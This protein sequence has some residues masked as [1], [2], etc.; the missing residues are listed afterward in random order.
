MLRNLKI[1]NLPEIEEKVLNFWERNKIFEK[2][3]ALRKAKG[4]PF[5]FF[6]GPPTANGLPHVGHAL[7]RAFKD[8]VLRY[9]TM[10]GRYVSRRAGWDTHG[11]P[12]EIAVE[13]ELG[14]KHKSE[15]EKLGIAEFN[16]MAKLSVWRYKGEWERFTKRIGFWLDFSNPYITYENSYMETLWWIFGEIEKRGLLKKLHK[17]IPWCTRCQTPL[18]NNE[19]AQPSAYQKVKD[20][21]VYFKLPLDRKSRGKAGREYLLVWTTT[22]WTIPANVAVA[23]NPN[24]TY[25]KFKVSDGFVWSHLP[26]PEHPGVEAVAVEKMAGAKFVGKSYEPAYPARSLSSL[27]RKRIYRVLPADFVSTN[28]G[29][30]FVHISPAFGEDDFKLIQGENFG[31][32]PQE[33]IP[34]FITLDERG[35]MKKGFPGAGKFMKDADHDVI[36]DL[37]R[38]GFLYERGVVEHNYPFCWRCETPL[39]YLAR[40]T[41]FIEMSKITSDLLA[42]NAGVNWIPSHIREGRFG[43]WIREGKD[44]SISRERYWGTPLPIWEGERCSHRLVV[45]SFE[46]L[47]KFAFTQSRF[48]LVRHGEG[49]QNVNGTLAG[50]PESKVN[51]PRLTRRGEEQARALGERL[52]A[53]KLHLIVASPN[54]R[55]RETARI[56]A[57]IAKAKVVLDQ[58]FREMDFGPFSGGTEERYRRFFENF[59]ERF[60]KRPPGGENLADVRGRM[61]EACQDLHRRFPG[62]R[63]A[64]VSHG[65]PLWMLEAAAKG[66]SPERVRDAPY[67][68]FAEY[69]EIRFPNWPFSR[70]GELDFHRPFVDAIILRCP[71]C[72]GRMRRVK[73]VADVWFDSG[74]MP[75]AQWHYPF[76]HREMV[77]GQPRRRRV[78]VPTS[79]APAK[80]GGALGFP[81]DY[82]VEGMDQTRGWFYTLLAVSVLL[83]R[84]PSYRNVISTGLVLDKFGQKMSK[85]KGNVV[86]PMAVIG[87]YGADALRWYLYT[88]NDPADPKR[89]DEGE[90]GKT[91][92]RLFLVLWNSYAFFETYR[93]E[94]MRP[95][96]VLDQ[97]ILAR[98][99]ET[100]REATRRLD[101]F[102]I[103]EAARLT[104]VFVED[105]SRW[106]I[107]RSRKNVSPKVLEAVLR[108]TA[109]LLAPFTPFFS[110]ALYQSVADAK[111]A[112]RNANDAKSVHLSDWPHAGKT[113]IDKKL[114]SAMAGVRRLASAAL[115]AREKA[116]VK[117]RQPLASLKIK[118]Q[119]SNLKNKELLQLLKDE[120]NVKEITFDSKLKTELELD[121]AITPELYEEG[122]VR[123]VTRMVQKLRQDAGLH[124]KD[125]IALRVE[126]PTETLAVIEKHSRAFKDATKAKSLELVAWEAESAGKFDAVL[127]SKLD[128]K[129][130]KL[131]L[132]KL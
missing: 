18:S 81:A 22:P 103:G 62:K 19:L 33:M 25:T 36:A 101:D 45:G 53:E 99:T 70:E 43:E 1:L 2:S 123:E 12:V 6:E 108:E 3:V 129:P 113:K 76:E 65:D 57:R 55:A 86:D 17:V 10:R 75:F 4:K 91:I 58:R 23:V 27:V 89:F 96:A 121:T 38:R 109:K 88:V 46:D 84:G 110:E 63:I 8:I 105:L 42:A 98:L 15:I 48:F 95:I 35:I 116:G 90:L 49:S 114:L 132:R 118:N 21:S 37:D 29:T 120:V 56:I 20:P 104:E 31:K 68:G 24:A 59:E 92:R 126:A 93:G 44:W 51:P 28:E 130:I 50:F 14:I 87:K 102:Q 124:F 112:E 83:K 85:S 47:N 125:A 60:V 11:L 32:R 80:A 100:V 82:I 79:D 106:Y 61:V 128:E 16:R 9:Q 40:L 30:G 127:E 64:I 97:W 5:R 94:R 13:K 119:I 26:P 34:I 78:G 117:V 72:K 73:E 131:Q 54:M 66:I 71:E 69:H 7:S 74:A 52:K 77:D 39:I 122:V 41:W 111:N 115:A 67:L 107:R